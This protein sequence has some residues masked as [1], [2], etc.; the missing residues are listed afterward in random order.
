MYRAIDTLF[1]HNPH[2]GEV[3]Q[4]SDICASFVTIDAACA[5]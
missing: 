3:A 2:G 1:K 5:S 4:S